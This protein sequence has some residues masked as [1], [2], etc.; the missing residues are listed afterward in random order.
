MNKLIIC[1]LSV[2]DNLFDNRT[3]GKT[4]FASVLDREYRCRKPQLLP[5]GCVFVDHYFRNARCKIPN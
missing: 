4:L 2:P 1:E 3:L 5:G